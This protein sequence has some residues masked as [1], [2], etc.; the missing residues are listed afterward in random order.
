MDTLH[1]LHLG[2]MNRIACAFLW[3]LIHLNAYEANG[4]DEEQTVINVQ[5]LKDGL[6]AWYAR[7]ARDKRRGLGRGDEITQLAHLTTYFG[8]T[9]ETNIKNEG[10]GHVGCLPIPSGAP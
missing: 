5:Y 10:S 7:M 6:F 4:D 9:H 1:C 8:S 2:V 3:R